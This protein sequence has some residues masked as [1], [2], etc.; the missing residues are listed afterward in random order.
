MYI[1]SGSINETNWLIVAGE[2]I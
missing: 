2:M 1:Q